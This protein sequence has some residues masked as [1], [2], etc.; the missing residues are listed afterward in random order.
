[1]IIDIGQ[2]VYSVLSSPY[3][4]E[5]KVTDGNQKFYV[6]FYL[7]VVKILF[8]HQSVHIS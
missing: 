6:N 5:V 7:K 4:L 1:M 3:D 8:L 2:I